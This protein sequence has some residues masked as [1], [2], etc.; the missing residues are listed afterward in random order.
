[1]PAFLD[2]PTP[3]AIA[4][5]GGAEELPENTLPAFDAAIELGYLHLETDAHVSSDGVVFSFHDHVLERVTDRRGRLVDL[6]A[7]EILT[8]DA[9]YHFSPDGN[10]FPHRGTGIRVPTMEEVLTRWPGVFVNIDTKSDA[11]V[12]PLVELLRRLDAVDRVC[13]GSFSDDRL[14]R[15][16]RLCGGAICTSMGPAG[17]TAAWLAS[18]SGRM[19]RLRADCVQVPVRARRL[20]VV[21]R[22]FLDA[23]HAAGLQVHVWT[24]DHAAEMTEL[25]ELG[26][27]AIMTD[28]P[29]LLREVLVARGQWHGAALARA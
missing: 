14:R 23:A 20:V 18:R 9:A 21:D 8:A 6:T 10:T 24:I 26:V 2:H 7:A 27:D 28:R 12:E 13:I 11:V 5:R 25:L 3:I 4:H 1:M 15:V 29:R 17:I 19:P 16:R 22:R